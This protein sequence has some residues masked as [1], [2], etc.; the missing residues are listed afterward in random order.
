MLEVGLLVVNEGLSLPRVL[1]STLEP[2][3]CSLIWVSFLTR[4]D[5]QVESTVVVVAKLP[6]TDTSEFN[7][8]AAA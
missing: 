1:R 6:Y 7:P 5:L 4:L 3:G 2:I 8:V